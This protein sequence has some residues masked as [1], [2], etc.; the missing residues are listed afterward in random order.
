MTKEDQKPNIIF[1][2][3]DALNPLHLGCYG[4]RRGT[5]PNIDLLARDG[6][7]FANAL[8]SNNATEKSFISIL[9][10]RQVLIK[11]SRDPLVSGDELKSFFD[12][13]GVFLQEI[14]KKEGYKTYCLRELQNWQKKGFDFSYSVGDNI[15]G[16]IGGTIRNKWLKNWLKKAAHYLPKDISEKIKVQYGRAKSEEFTE[17]AIEII[18]NSQKNKEKFFMFVYYD[19]THIPYNPRQFTGKFRVEDRGRNFFSEI[20]D[21]NYNPKLV[22]YWKNAFNKDDCIGDIIANYDSTVFYEDFLIGKIIEELKKTG[23]IESTIIFIFS[24]HGE[25]MDKHGIYF[26]HHELY[27]SSMR[28][29][30]IISGKNIPRSK[31]IDSLVQ[32]KDFMPTV[33]DITGRKYNAADFDGKS[34]V[35]LLR[36]GRKI[37]DFVFMEEGDKSKKRAIRTLNYKYIEAKSEEDAFCKYCNKIHGGVIELY[38]LKKDPG[39]TENI[40]DDNGEIIAKMKEEIDSFLKSQK[41]NDEKRRIRTLFQNKQD[42]L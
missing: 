1:I 38:D 25:S 7:L 21:K 3:I 34:I 8:S 39:E 17:K 40:A 15:R 33:L 30:L 42:I 16:G 32:H 10:G 22:E 5:S 24:D 35:P 31:K 12:S 41:Q 26:D 37:R 2:M 14:L 19:D 6:M 23:A 28:I 13:G 18:K 4:Y 27:D 9:S 11:D 36:K 29:P 20:S